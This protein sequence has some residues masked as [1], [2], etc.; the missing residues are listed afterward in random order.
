[1]GAEWYMQGLHGELCKAEPLNVTTTIDDSADVRRYAWE[2][3]EGELLVA[4]QS[5]R[6]RRRTFRAVLGFTG[7]G[8]ARWRLLLIAKRQAVVNWW[9]RWG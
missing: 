8:P 2:P 6:E 7:K 9:I 1:M 5:E 4:E 3:I